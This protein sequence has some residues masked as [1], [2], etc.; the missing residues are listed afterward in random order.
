MYTLLIIFTQLFSPVPSTS[1]EPFLNSSVFSFEVFGGNYWCNS[2]QWNVHLLCL[3]WSLV[4]GLLL[5]NRHPSQDR[6]FPPI[7]NSFCPY[8]PLWS[9][10][11]SASFSLFSHG[12]PSARI[13]CQSPL[14][15]NM[16]FWYLSRS[17]LWLTVYCRLIFYDTNISHNF[18][19]SWIKSLFIHSAGG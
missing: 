9:L 8:L 16:F 5:S 4:V 13:L 6:T 12:N 18:S 17:Y 15:N 19:Y 10:L 14:L 3:V 11:P 1:A 2:T 7:P